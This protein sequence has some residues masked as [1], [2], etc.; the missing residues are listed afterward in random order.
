MINIISASSLINGQKHHDYSAVTMI[1][2]S[3]LEWP[4]RVALGNQIE[5]MF[6]YNNLIEPCSYVENQVEMSA[7]NATHLRLRTNR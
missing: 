1:K 5:Q 3:Y 7:M 4:R 6:L 2:N